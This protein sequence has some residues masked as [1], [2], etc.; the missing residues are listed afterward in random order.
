MLGAGIA[1]LTSLAWSISSICVK[2]VADRV[3]SLII[4]T[5]RTWVGSALLISLVMVTGRYE[6]LSQISWESFVYV[7]SSGIL[8]MA[9]GD[10]IYIKSVS[11][12]DVSIAFPL[13]QCAFIL[14]TVLSAI[15]F[16]G[17]QFTWI[18]ITG[19]VLV[20]LGIYLM[21]SSRGRGGVPTDRKRV[22]PKGLFFILIAILAWTGATLLLKI[23]VTGVDPFIAACLRI[24]TSAI[25]LFFFFHSRPNKENTPLRQIS[26]KNLA[27]VASAGFLTYG[28]AAVGYISAIQL[29]GAGKTVLLTAIAPIFALPFAIFILGE[30]PTR[31]TLLGVMISVIGVWLVVVK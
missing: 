9:I 30:K 18:T 13:S 28:V 4:N 17:E 15:L 3:E 16:L 22:N 6:T 24:S 23:G 8:A 21:T 27:L 29:I 1:L 20:V 14:L 2:L 5:L 7:V 31:Y 25:V 11:L 26:K 12:L 10:T 19:G